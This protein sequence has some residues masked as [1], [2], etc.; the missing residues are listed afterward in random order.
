MERQIDE[1]NLF[2]SS[3]S[4]P[5]D[6]DD[7]DGGGGWGWELFQVRN[8]TRGQIGRRRWWKRRGKKS[9]SKNLQVSS[10]ILYICMYLLFMK[11]RKRDSSSEYMYVYHTIPYYMST[12]H[13]QNPLSYHIMLYKHRTIYFSILYYIPHIYHIKLLHGFRF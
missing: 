7:D 8:R 1:E 3:V 13:Q 12:V 2:I 9:S 10:R 6:D 11:S 4:Y 5:D